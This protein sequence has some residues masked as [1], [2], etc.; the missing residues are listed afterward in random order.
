[1]NSQKLNGEST[2]NIL[3]ILL[4]LVKLE[5]GFSRFETTYEVFTQG[6]TYVVYIDENTP[7]Y[8]NISLFINIHIHAFTMALYYNMA[9]AGVT[10]T[11]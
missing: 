3:L 10:R 1:M 4:T 9:A 11:P 2:R 7:I 6:S 8:Y 5:W